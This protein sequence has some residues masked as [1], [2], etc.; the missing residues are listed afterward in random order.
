MD[1]NIPDIR[2][3]NHPEELQQAILDNLYYTQGKSAELA[4]LNDWYMA[5]SYTV[6]DRMMKHWIGSLKKFYKK[7]IKIVG[8]LSAEFLL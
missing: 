7:G 4:T 5:V 8:Y 2:H 1:N 3:G 6:R